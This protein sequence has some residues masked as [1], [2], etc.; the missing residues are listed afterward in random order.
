MNDK[1]VIMIV[2]WIPDVIPRTPTSPILFYKTLY[3][4]IAY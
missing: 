3:K 2:D 4:H 1:K